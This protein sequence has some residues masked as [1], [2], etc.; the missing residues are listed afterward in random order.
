MVAFFIM[1]KGKHPYGKSYEIES[2]IVED[3]PDLTAV[4]DE[5][6]CDMLTSM[7][8]G[9]PTKRPSAAKLQR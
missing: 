1:T 2:N 4:K 3:N 8:A 9:D 5:V 7:L 6:A